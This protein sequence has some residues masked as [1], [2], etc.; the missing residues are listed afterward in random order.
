LA[1]NLPKL[2]NNIILEDEKE[3]CKL[4]DLLSKMLD[5]NYKT[6]ISAKDALSHPFF[7]EQ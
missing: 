5:V 6:R 7:E 1:H 4:I 2:L 3:K